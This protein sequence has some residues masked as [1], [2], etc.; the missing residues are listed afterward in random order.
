MDD[1]TIEE[2]EAWSKLGAE[3]YNLTKTESGYYNDNDTL[4]A[5]YGWSA[6]I[7]AYEKH[8][9]SEESIVEILKEYCFG[10]MDAPQ[11]AKEIHNLLTR[12]PKN[13]RQTN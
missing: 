7:A 8:L 12:K 10:D 1:K 11:A 6:A 5:W 3:P 13:D 4:N 2:F 9:P